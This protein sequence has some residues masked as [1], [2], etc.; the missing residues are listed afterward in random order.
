MHPLTPAA[1][2][3]RCRLPLGA[4]AV[5]AALA[6]AACRGP[7]DA[8]LDPAAAPV[9]FYASTDPDTI[10]R[11]GVYTT[12]DGRDLAYVAH[13]A[14]ADT[15]LVY[16]HGIESHAG[17]FDEAADLLCG[18]GF[19]VYCL[20]RRG[21]GINRENRGFPSG[22]VDTYETLFRDLDAFMRP[23][24]D[25]YDALY[26]VGLSWGG[27]LAMGYA[28]SRPEA[29]DGLVLITPGLRALVDKPAGEKLAIVTA[30]G[31]SPRSYFTTP[32]D[33]EMFTTTPHVLEGI[34]ADPLRLRLV[35]ARFLMESTRLEWAIDEMMP[36]NRLPILL[37]LAGQDRII[38]NEGVV[39]VL[40]RG[41][42]SDLEVV[43][44]EDRTHSIQ[45][46]APERLVDDMAGWI[47]RQEAGRSA[48]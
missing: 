44:Y 48:R 19:D 7:G 20:D 25:E 27:K 17:W 10:R 18:R 24:R 4:A 35:T 39:E 15:A 36:A 37:V 22:H 31:L 13:H 43:T 12:A 41:S 38:D 11:E 47:R 28:L 9:G 21:S 30:S 8:A 32:I 33:P 2:R 3:R 45:F 46:D 29:A 23:M 14:R 42:R 16:L 40:R 5:T 34:V 26:L 1:P 6:M